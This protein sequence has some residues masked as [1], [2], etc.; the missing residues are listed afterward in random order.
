[1]DTEPAEITALPYYEPDTSGEQLYY[2]QYVPRGFEAIPDYWLRD[3][4]GVVPGCFR[5]CGGR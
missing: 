2:D 4:Q 5:R 3:G 1:M